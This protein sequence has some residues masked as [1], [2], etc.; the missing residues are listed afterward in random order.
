MSTEDNK[1]NSIVHPCESESYTDQLNR[2]MSEMDFAG[3]EKVANLI[4][5]SHY[6]TAVSI[7]RTHQLN[8]N[9]LIVKIGHCLWHWNVPGVVRGDSV[10]YFGHDSALDASHCARMATFQKQ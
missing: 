2:F 8:I 7:I 10:H 3:Q 5:Y 4:N 6:A 9:I 1:K